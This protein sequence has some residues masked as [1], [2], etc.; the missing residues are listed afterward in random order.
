M[1]ATV[2]TPAGRG[3]HRFAGWAPG[4][5]PVRRVAASRGRDRRAR[6]RP[7]SPAH[8]SLG[9]GR[10]ACVRAPPLVPRR[11]RPPVTVRVS[12]HCWRRP[13]RPE[14]TG[15]GRGHCH[16]K[17]RRPTVWTRSAHGIDMCPPAARRPATASDAACPARPTVAGC[18]HPRGWPSRRTP[19][20]RWPSGVAVRPHRWPSMATSRWPVS[21]HGRAGRGHR[22]PW[23][24]RRRPRMATAPAVMA[25]RSGGV[26]SPGP[27]PP[28]RGHRRTR[29]RSLPSAVATPAPRVRSPAVAL[30]RAGIRYAKGPV[31]LIRPVTGGPAATRFRSHRPPRTWVRRGGPFAR[32]SPRRWRRACRPGECRSCGGPARGEPLCGVRYR[33]VACHE[34][35]TTLSDFLP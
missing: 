3:H 5:R 12:R 9:G 18:P 13:R 26:R 8:R 11:G 15:Q 35:G 20:R 31:T 25:T 23:P 19:G 16:G 34:H 14:H 27:W 30:V 17:R 32:R 28:S 2:A 21:G 22:C 10:S 24:W 6:P 33:T 1:A 4:H 7:R 29:R